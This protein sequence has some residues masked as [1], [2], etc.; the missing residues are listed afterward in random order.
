MRITHV[1]LYQVIQQEND[2]FANIYLWKWIKLVINKRGFEQQVV[3][4]VKRFKCAAR[5]LGRA[6][7]GKDNKKNAWNLFVISKRSDGTR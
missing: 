5:E 3:C 6:R 7:R 1:N 4:F 2:G